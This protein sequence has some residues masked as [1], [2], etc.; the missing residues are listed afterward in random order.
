MVE[1]LLYSVPEVME[2][3]S[4]S[5]S[6]IYELIRAGELHAVK[7]GRRRLISAKALDEYVAGLSDHAA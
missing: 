3:L 7:V 2:R 5:R 4:L 1:R 6:V